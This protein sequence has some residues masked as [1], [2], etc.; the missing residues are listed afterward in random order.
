MENKKLGIILIIIGLIV[1]ALILY[2]INVLSSR[3]E[4]LGCFNNPDC[5]PIERG[6]S[7]SHI[8]IGVFAFIIALGF[9]LIFFNKT[10]DRLIKRFGEEKDNDKFEFAMKFLDPF[11]AKVLRKIREENGVTQSTLRLKLDMSKAKLSY[12]LQDLEKR[13]LI[14]R[15]EKGKTLAIYLKI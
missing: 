13:G 9:Y 15:V 12:V 11:E 4:V 6:L 3:A 5:L 14:K 1:G 10:E 2:Y 7:V 8:G